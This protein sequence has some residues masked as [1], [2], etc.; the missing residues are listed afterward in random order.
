M[1]Y[2][3]EKKYISRRQFLKNAG[4]VG[5]GAAAINLF[6]LPVF[7]ASSEMGGASGGMASGD[8]SF[9]QEKNENHLIWQVNDWKIAPDPIP[10]SKIKNELGTQVLIIGGG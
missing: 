6:G 9:A 4:A 8:F 10:D 3:M 2:F 1:T 7:A 5:L